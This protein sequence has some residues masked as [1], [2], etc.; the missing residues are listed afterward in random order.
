[1]VS[2]DHCLPS[3][4]LIEERHRSE[5]PVPRPPA[6]STPVREQ[7]GIPL[8]SPLP[9]LPLCPRPEPVH[10]CRAGAGHPAHTTPCITARTRNQFS[11]RPWSG[12]VR[13]NNTAGATAL[14][15]RT[16]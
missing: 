3:C 12:P 14:S 4:D 2:T 16:R 1:M 7:A 13:Y 5:F 6:Q 15:T 10:D 11:A 8:H 9:S